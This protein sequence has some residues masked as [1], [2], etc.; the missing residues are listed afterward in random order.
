MEENARM[1]ESLIERTAEYGKTSFE[2]IK[3]KAIDKTSEVVSSFLPNTIV[4]VFYLTFIFFL[5]V[6]VAIW[7]GDM[8]GGASYGFFVV[9]AFYFVTGLFIHFVLYKWLKRLVCNNFIKQVLN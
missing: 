9:A 2:L 7:L 6:G 1:V 4:V 8:L 5:S 3:L